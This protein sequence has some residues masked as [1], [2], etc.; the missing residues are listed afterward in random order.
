MCNIILRIE[1]KKSVF[2]ANSV[3]LVQ[4]QADFLAKNLPYRV[5]SFVGA[6]G[7]DSWDDAKWNEAL[8]GHDVLVFIHDVFL[9]ALQRR[10]LGWDRVNVLIVDE[11]HHASGVRSLVFVN[12]S[13][14]SSDS[15]I[16]VTSEFSTTW[17]STRG[18]ADALGPGFSD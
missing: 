11:C 7:V 18:W 17:S 4:Q 6:D 10:S 5:R 3:S 2:V 16:R 15:R 8:D 12:S 14:Y 9:M 13:C 1:G